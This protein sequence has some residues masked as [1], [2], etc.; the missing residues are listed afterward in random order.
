MA[1]ALAPH[2]LNAFVVALVADVSF[3]AVG[4]GGVVIFDP[5]VPARAARSREAAPERSRRPVARRARAV[6]SQPH[7]VQ[8][9]F[10]T[11]FAFGVAVAGAAAAT[12][13]AQHDQ[14]QQSFP[15]DSA[16]RVKQSQRFP[17]TDRLCG[18][19][20]EMY[21]NAEMPPSMIVRVL[22]VMPVAPVVANRS[23]AERSF[24]GRSAQCRVPMKG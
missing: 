13:K 14:R 22:T 2:V 1:V 21:R 8:R 5:R 15:H 24:A 23:R 17:R 10:T 20:R 12:G 9:R 18:L 7:A 19:S 11:L 6:V 16:S 4:V 3:D